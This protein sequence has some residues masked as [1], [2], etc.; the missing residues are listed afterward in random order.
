[1]SDD[2]LSAFI[3]SGIRVQN[4]K[5]L[6]DFLA[7]PD[8]K[9]TVQSSSF[10]QVFFTLKTLGLADA[11]ALLPFVTAKQV[12][13]FIDLDCWRKDSFVR[14]PFIEWIAVFAEVGPEETVH[15]LSGID[16]DV[17]ALFLKDLITVY[18]IERD[19]P[20]LATELVFSPD[21][22]F[23]VHQEETGDAA[24]IASL[25]VDA[26]FRHTPDLGYSVIRRVRYTTRT[27]LEETAYQNKVRRL[28]VHGF[29]DYYEA[30][31]IYAGPE[32]DETVAQP[33]TDAAADEGIPGEDL[34]QLLPTIFANSLS[35]RGFLLT[36]LGAVPA[37]ESERLA[38][39]LTALGNRILSANL[40][41]LGE[42]DG[43]RVA[44]GELRDFL[45]IG[46]EHLSNG[47]LE[48]APRIL[49]ANHVQNV[50]KAGFDH[51]ARLRDLAEGLA[52]FPSFTPDLLESPDQEFF[53]G[54]LR[55][56]PLLWEAGEYRNFRSMADV[57]DT[58]KRME[59]IRIM[60][61][62]FLRLFASSDTT[63][64]RTFNT[65]VIRQ[66]ISGEFQP[67]PLEAKALEGFLSD[68]VKFPELAL[69]GELEPFASRW[70]D[71]LR[72]ELEPLVGKTIDPRFIGS[73]LMR[74]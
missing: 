43:I 3:G 38:Q 16:E 21:N 59:D 20:P 47:D 37:R 5:Q 46:L 4:K 41:N 24:S 53:N 61:Q 30:L 15:A 56:K 62:G 8:A 63:L 42:V 23:A 64:R 34:P 22:R 52:G 17:I 48:S 66:A 6:E 74:L 50:F 25:I 11:I 14:R 39:E 71:T 57:E 32:A 58:Q 28:D 19:E 70:L 13:G 54:L 67:A 35:D 26:L 36:A 10:E 31:S 33:R 72:T 51:L 60:S 49:S 9:E 45:T 65:A 55:F 7:L 2:V 73:V 29:V 44:L 1:M 69:P 68:R 12:C 40:V 27:E 18:E